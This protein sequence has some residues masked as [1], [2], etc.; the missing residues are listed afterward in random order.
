[1]TAAPRCRRCDDLHVL[2]PEGLCITCVDAV[3][4]EFEA[5]RPTCI[6]CGDWDDTVAMRPVTKTIHAR[7]CAPCGA[8]PEVLAVLAEED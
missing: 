7:L 6:A 1:M 5:S 4:R 8:S 2:N 3:D